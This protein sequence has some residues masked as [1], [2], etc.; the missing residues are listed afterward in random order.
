MNQPM[1]NKEFVLNYFNAMSGIAKT[2]E[3]IANWVTDLKLIEHK[4]FFESTFPKYEMFADEMTSEGNRIVVKAHLTGR[5]EGVLNDIQPT[6][7]EVNFPF[8]IAYVIENNKIVSHWLVAD[9]M[10]LMEQLG[11]YEPIS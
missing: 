3:L 5:H 2:R 9:Q 11:V 7:K 1:K 8:I 6:F 10:I 4:L